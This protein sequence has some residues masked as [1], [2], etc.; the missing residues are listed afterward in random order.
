MTARGAVSCYGCL[1]SGRIVGFATNGAECSCTRCTVCD[2]H[3][4]ADTLDR[5]LDDEGRGVAVCP[6]CRGELAETRDERMA[7]QHYDETRD[8]G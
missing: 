1:G 3:V 4:D 5:D 8:A 2:E 6:R 7:D